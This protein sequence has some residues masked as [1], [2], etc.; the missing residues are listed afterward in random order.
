[1]SRIGPKNV[2]LDA[3]S[4]EAVARRVADLLREDTPTTDMLTVA[5]VARRF[6]VSRDYV[7]RHADELGAV[8]VG[9]GSRPRL[10]FDLD[11]VA[12]ALTSRSEDRESDARKPQRKAKS[13]PR[14]SRGGERGPA[15]LPIRGRE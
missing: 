3:E 12:E 13:R 5:E 6:R 11:R 15:L 10:R 7:Y 8:R 1:V 4:V 2:H 14:R 9:N